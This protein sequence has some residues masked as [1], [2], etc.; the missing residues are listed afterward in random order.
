MTG[1]IIA[2]PFVALEVIVKSMMYILYYP[3]VLILAIIYPLI[4]THNLNWV[5][6]WY[7]YATTWRHGFYTGCIHRMWK[8]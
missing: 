8:D 7:S 6:N 1:N 2:L 3:L 5:D 4:K